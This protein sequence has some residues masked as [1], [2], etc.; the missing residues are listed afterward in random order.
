MIR[1]FFIAAG[2]AIGAVLRYGVSGLTHRVFGPIFPW[3]TLAVNLSGSFAIGLFW[4]VFERA[5]LSPNARLFIFIGL[6]GAFTTFSTFSLETLN[7]FRDGEMK[8]A[9]SNIFLSN[10]LGIA[11]VFAG[12]AVSRSLT[13]IV[14]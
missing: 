11:L 10:F 5:A 14:K 7:L 1:L 6:L 2:G 12:L 8:L 13:N 4:G 3:G 9:L